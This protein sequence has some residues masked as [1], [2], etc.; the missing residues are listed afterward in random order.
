MSPRH[1]IA[2][3]ALFGFRSVL[4]VNDKDESLAVAMKPTAV[5]FC[6]D[7][8]VQSFLVFA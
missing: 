3:R 7:A 6:D 4:M 8:A 2:V 5:L 1:W